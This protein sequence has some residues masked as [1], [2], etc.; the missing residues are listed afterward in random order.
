MR[1]L[2]KKNHLYFRVVFDREYKKLIIDKS[3]VKNKKGK[4]RSEFNLR[5]MCPSQISGIH[6]ATSDPKWIQEGLKIKVL[7]IG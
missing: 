2:M 4:S 6:K 1:Y 7:R 5:N 3:E